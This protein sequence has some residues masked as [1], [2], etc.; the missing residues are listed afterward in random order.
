[1]E[2]PAEVKDGPSK[3][4]MSKI[5]R[6][7]T[8]LNKKIVKTDRRLV[9]DEEGNVSHPVAQFHSPFLRCREAGKTHLEIH[10][11]RGAR[12]EIGNDRNEG[13]RCH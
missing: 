5:Q 12:F 4:A 6:A 2:N 11:L 7:K 13:G 3:K 1:M 10:F 8:L 9:F